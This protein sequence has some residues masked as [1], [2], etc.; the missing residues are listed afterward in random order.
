MRINSTNPPPSSASNINQNNLTLQ[1]MI[2]HEIEF[3]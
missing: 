1:S 2:V 3:A